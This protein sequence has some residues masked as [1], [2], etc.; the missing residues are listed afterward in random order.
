M[1]EFFF[2][3]NLLLKQPVVKIFYS[4]LKISFKPFVFKSKP[5]FWS[6]EMT[7]NLN[8]VIFVFFLFFDDFSASVICFIIIIVFWLLV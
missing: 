5:R 8:F 4:R 2:T 3:S 1:F 7:Y 6:C